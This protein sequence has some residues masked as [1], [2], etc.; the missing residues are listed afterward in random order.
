[1]LYLILLL[2]FLYL[3]PNIENNVLSWDATMNQLVK[4]LQ[5]LAYLLRCSHSIGE[6][7]TQQGGT[8]KQSGTF[9]LM[10]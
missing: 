3:Q 5:L 7:Q 10:I 1:M 9:P 8:P 4:Q 2:E 6:H